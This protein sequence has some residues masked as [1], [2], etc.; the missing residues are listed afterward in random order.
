MQPCSV[1]PVDRRS[2]RGG[3]RHRNLRANRIDLFTFRRCQGRG[4]APQPGEF[5]TADFFE[6]MMERTGH[7]THAV[8]KGKRDAAGVH[9]K[10]PM[11]RRGTRCR[12]HA[13]PDIRQTGG[14]YMRIP[15]PE[16]F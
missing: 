8:L 14:R 15:H 11:K 3:N 16:S 9:T 4:L 10:T 7:G 6:P 2:D 12:H 13:L 5:G 1:R